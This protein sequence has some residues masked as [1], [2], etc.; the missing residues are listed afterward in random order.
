MTSYVNENVPHSG[1]GHWLAHTILCK[2]LGDSS[3]A[4]LK[5]H[6][7]VVVVSKGVVLAELTWNIRGKELLW[8]ADQWKANGGLPRGSSWPD[9]KNHAITWRRCGRK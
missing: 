5:T 7:M 4:D 9:K 6:L 2:N 3:D 1:V 8:H